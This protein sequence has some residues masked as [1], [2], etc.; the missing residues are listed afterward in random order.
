MFTMVSYLLVAVVPHFFAQAIVG[1]S[2]DS[3]DIECS[4][5]AKVMVKV[6]GADGGNHVFV[7]TDEGDATGH[8]MVFA[9]ASDEVKNDGGSEKHHVKLRRVV[10]SDDGEHGWLGVSLVNVWSRDAGEEEVGV[11]ITD[12]VDGSPADQVGLQAKDVVV[13]ID[14]EAI[15]TNIGELVKLVAANKPGDEIDVVVIRD[16]EEKA[17]TVTLGSRDESQKFSWKFHTAPLA[18]IEEKIHTSAKFLQRGDDGEWIFKDLGDLSDVEGLPDNIKMLM[19][20]VGSHMVKI[21]VDDGEE[22]VHITSE[23]DGV[24]ISV[25]QDGDGPITVTR[26][27][28]NGDETVETYANIDELRAADT[29][30]AELLEGI[31]NQFEIKIDDLDLGDLNFDFNIDFDADE[32]NDSILLWQQGMEDFN[33]TQK[34]IA[35]AQLQIQEALQ[36]IEGM[37]AL[38]DELLQSL[39]QVSGLNRLKGA[40]HVMR[41]DGIK[42]SFEVRPDG[43]IEVKVRK[44][45]SELIELYENEDDLANRNPDL[46]KKYQ[47]VRAE[48]N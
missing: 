33:K 20:Q 12:V 5:T 28:G 34:D 19:P 38:P 42:Q 23:H 29:E 26:S 11:V 13:S 44:G 47:D 4:K 41:L 17:F 43:V 2:S 10:R 6:V 15:G 30:A 8:G 7:T 31:D 32:L 16:G 37:G 1:I 40:P 18:E 27:D 22:S 46:F 21:Y 9:F 3:D 48:L 14:G 39:S 36:Q 24:N 45:D 35:L 25:E